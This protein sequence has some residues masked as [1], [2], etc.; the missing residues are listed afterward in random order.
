[1]D[2]LT[3][4]LHNVSIGES[5]DSEI[6]GLTNGVTKLS[7]TPKK[8]TQLFPNTPPK[9]VFGQKR[10]EWKILI[11][12]YHH[13]ERSPL[14]R[15]SIAKRDTH[16]NISFY[17]LE[18]DVQI[19]IQIHDFIN[20]KSGNIMTMVRKSPMKDT[21]TKSTKTRA[22]NCRTCGQHRTKNHAC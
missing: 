3:E 12:K 14:R 21:P 10:V 15:L 16:G 18:M 5:T 13:A 1:M 22:Y 17:R 4:K 6:E 2:G 9:G 19:I 11:S 20:P 8:K 7:I